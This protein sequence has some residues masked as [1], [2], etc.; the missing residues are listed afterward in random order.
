[1]ANRL[2]RETSRR[3]TTT[4]EMQQYLL[5]MYVYGWITVAEREGVC[6]ASLGLTSNISGTCCRAPKPL[7][8]LLATAVGLCD[9][10]SRVVHYLQLNRGVFHENHPF[11]PGKHRLRTVVAF[12]MAQIHEVVHR[13]QIEKKKASFPRVSFA[14]PNACQ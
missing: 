13:L 2:K 5:S 3:T 10:I 11:R 4:T 8:P 6:V 14:F 7:L 12:I 1:M 9:D